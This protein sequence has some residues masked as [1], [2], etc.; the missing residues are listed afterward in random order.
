MRAILVAGVALALSACG[1][2]GGD[3]AANEA[4]ALGADNMMMDENLM[5]DPNMS[6]NG[7]TGMEG[8]MGGNDAMG[9][10]NGAMDANTQNMMQKDAATN[11]PDTNL[12]NGL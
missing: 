3:P 5:L 4:N 1:G 6:M 7:A 11:D 2:S 8:S 9:G 10:G 12:A